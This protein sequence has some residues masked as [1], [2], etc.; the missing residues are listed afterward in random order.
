M[1]LYLKQAKFKAFDLGRWLELKSFLKLLFFT[2]A[3]TPEY[4]EFW[5]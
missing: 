2:K 5:F 1:L 3:T 4:P